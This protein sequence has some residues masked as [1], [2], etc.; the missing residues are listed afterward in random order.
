M[1]ALAE[2]EAT[3]K[4]SREVR[5]AATSNWRKS[6]IEQLGSSESLNYFSAAEETTS[7]VSLRIRH[8]KTG[9]WMVKDELAKVF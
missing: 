5:E 8:P 2:M 7:I 9:K 1:A 4:F 6:V 3:L